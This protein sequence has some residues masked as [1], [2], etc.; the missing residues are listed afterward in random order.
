[1][2]KLHALIAQC[3]RELKQS[4]EAVQICAA[5][6]KIYPDDAELLFMESM[7]L[8][9][10]A[11]HRGAEERLHRLINGREDDHFSS[12]DAGLRG[13]KARHNLAVICVDQ[14]RFSEAETHWCVAIQDEPAFIPAQLGLGEMYAKNK[15]WDKLEAHVQ[16]LNQ[17]GPRGEEV[18]Q[19]LLGQ[20]K[21]V[22]GELSA[23]RFRLKT[24]STQ[25][26]KSLRIKRLLAE[27]TLKEGIDLPAAE[28][29]LREILELDPNDEKAG[30]VIE[31]IQKKHKPGANGSS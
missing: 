27:V 15:N 17:L 23:A 7:I 8:R 21:M 19:Y 16:R 25:F 12:V 1:V 26:P 29:V 18:G 11:D 2:R 22:A 4:A 30:K 14:Q 6:R 28:Q 9:E 10:R 3:H 20:G 13:Y 31:G 24:A 5:G